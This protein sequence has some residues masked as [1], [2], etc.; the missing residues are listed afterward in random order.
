[1]NKLIASVLAL[2]L[3]TSCAE[4]NLNEDDGD[5]IDGMRA[6]GTIVPGSQ[7]DLHYNIGDTIYFDFDSSSL[8]PESKDLAKEQVQWIN[9]NDKAVIIEG[10]CDERG[11]RDYNIGLGERRAHAVKNYMLSLG[12]TPDRI[13]TVSYGK[14]RPAVVGSGEDVWTKNRR[15]V[16]IVLK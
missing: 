13:D 15:A 9:Q 12:V 6:D 11:T 10:H 8:N 16:T 14:E 1:M 7:A 3:I 4:K 5:V 2:L